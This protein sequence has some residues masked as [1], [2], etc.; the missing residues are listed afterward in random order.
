[1]TQNQINKAKSKMLSSRYCI[2]YEKFN[3]KL[4]TKR[5]TLWHLFFVKYNYNNNNDNNNKTNN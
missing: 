1:M 2:I 3:D 5:N 4:L